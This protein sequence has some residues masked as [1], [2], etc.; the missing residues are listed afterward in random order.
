MK[1]Y[2]TRSISRVAALTLL[3]LLSTAGMTFAY[4]TDK[5]V[6][7]PS[8]YYTFNPPSAGSS[9]GDPS[10]GSTVKRISA[11]R[12]TASSLTNGN[13][14]MITNEYA[15]MSPFNIDDTRLI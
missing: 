3:A 2:S 5:A 4:L 10:F 6:H 12:S 9:Y 14:G 13:L 8:N 11:A 7:A 15:T 1:T